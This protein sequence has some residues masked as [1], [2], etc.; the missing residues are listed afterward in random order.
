MI[1]EIR[2][3]CKCTH[4]EKDLFEICNRCAQEVF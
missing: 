2:V 1:K 3:N 4:C